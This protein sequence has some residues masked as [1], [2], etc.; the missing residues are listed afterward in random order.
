MEEKS[1]RASSWLAK[2]LGLSISTVERLRVRDPASLP[3]HLCIG[4][5]IRYDEAV[6]ESWLQARLAPPETGGNHGV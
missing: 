3:P 6:V 5:S 1:L 2:R 4:G